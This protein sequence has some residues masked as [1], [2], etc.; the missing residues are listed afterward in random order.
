MRL[1][2]VAGIWGSLSLSL[3]GGAVAR[4]FE[5]EAG[6]AAGAIVEADVPLHQ[7][8]QALAD[9]EAEAGAALL[10]RGGGVGLREAAEDAAVEGFRN[11]G[12]AILHRHPD[13]P[14]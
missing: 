5:P 4:Q 9:G 14:P 10:A 2:G 12:P 11:A 8:D 13:R 3:L 7:L 6:A 1:S